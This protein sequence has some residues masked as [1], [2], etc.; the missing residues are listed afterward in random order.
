[1]DD[2]LKEKLMTIIGCGISLRD[3]YIIITRLFE[4]INKE[5]Y[6]VV[7]KEEF[8][9]EYHRGY[10]DGQHAIREEQDES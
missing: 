9:E 1:M 8:K 2:I 6:V 10:R 4:T 7:K 3:R 5:G